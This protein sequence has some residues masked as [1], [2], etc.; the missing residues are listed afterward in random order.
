VSKEVTMNHDVPPQAGSKPKKPYLAPNVSHV[1]D[2]RI[3]ELLETE[4]KESGFG[5]SSHPADDKESL[6]SPRPT[7]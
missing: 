1:S 5:L 6:A 4:L 2:P 7:D 3:I